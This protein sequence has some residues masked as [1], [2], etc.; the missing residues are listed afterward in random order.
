M[1]LQSAC[2]KTK[3]ETAIGYN[4]L[5]KEKTLAHVSP[6]TFSSSGEREPTAREKHGL[7]VPLSLAHSSTETSP[8]PLRTSFES[9]KRRL[10][11][12]NLPQNSFSP[13]L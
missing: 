9:R 2:L 10:R 13:N 12:L 4:G 8:P 6:L 7:Q 3:S 11:F 1:I 5:S